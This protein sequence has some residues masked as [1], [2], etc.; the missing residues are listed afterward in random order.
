MAIPTFRDLTGL[1]GKALT[2]EAQQ[3]IMALQE[4]HLNLREQNARLRE[5]NAS[6]R[7][8][9][10]LKRKLRYEGNCYW[11]ANGDSKDGP[12]CQLCWDKE[13]KLVR[14]QKGYGHSSLACLSCQQGYE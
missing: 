5:E 4:E 6:L 14:L 10:E 11:I 3:T 8:E 7:A 13:Q 2:V 12:Y 1:L 9:L